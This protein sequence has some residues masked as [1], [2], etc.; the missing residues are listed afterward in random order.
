MHSVKKSLTEYGDKIDAS[1]KESIETAI[2]NLEAAL[3]LD[4][5]AAIEE[6]STALM[7]SLI[8]I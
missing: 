8:H 2:K 4:D 1:E 7:L 6:K 3:K 5:K